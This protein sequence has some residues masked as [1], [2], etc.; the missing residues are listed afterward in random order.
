MNRPL[1]SAITKLGLTII[2][3]AAMIS[4]PTSFFESRRSICLFKNLLDTECYGC[5]M[6]RAISHVFHGNLNQ[7][8]NYNKAVVVVFPLLCYITSVYLVRNYRTCKR[9][10]K[11]KG[12]RFSI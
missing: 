9:I 6:T 12:S 8:F 4:V 2:G 7:A 5:G 11:E 3:I 1:L 10:L